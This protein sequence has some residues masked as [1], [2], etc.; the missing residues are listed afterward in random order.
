MLRQILLTS[1]AITACATF[2]PTKV[3]A[4][5]LTVF[6]EDSLEKKQG[7]SITFKVS[8]NPMT[9]E[10]VEIG[11]LTFVPDNGELSYDNDGSNIDEPGTII[12]TSTTVANLK[13]DVLPPKPVID[14]ESDILDVT[15]IYYIKL[16]SIKLPVAIVAKPL[17]DVV[18]APEENTPEPLT[19]LG[20]ATA[21][22][23]GAILK[24]ESLKNK[25]S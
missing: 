16:G 3:N 4:A 19:M 13:F 5:T 2:I 21:L 25:K 1:L 23:Y 24:R 20:A 6:T 10:P 22:G 8:F 14:G 9:D 15:L 7:Q 17:L 11:Q 12:A 18:P